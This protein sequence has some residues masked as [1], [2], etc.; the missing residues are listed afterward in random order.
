MERL[1]EKMEMEMEKNKIYFPKQ[2][3]CYLEN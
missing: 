3:E 1:I 2:F